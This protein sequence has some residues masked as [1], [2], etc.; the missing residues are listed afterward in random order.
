MYVYYLFAVQ[1]DFSV[2]M[3]P[4]LWITVD[5]GHA[6]GQ[7]WIFSYLTLVFFWCL[8]WPNG[9]NFNN[10][11]CIFIFYFCIMEPLEFLTESYTWQKDLQTQTHLSVT[12]NLQNLA[13]VVSVWMS[14]FI[15]HGKCTGNRKILTV[16]SIYSLPIF[17]C[18][19]VMSGKSVSSIS[20]VFNL[21][22]VPRPWLT[23]V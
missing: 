9:L 15:F 13:N 18:L 14:E 1:W 21:R 3:C 12:G 4:Q 20:A 23:P 7:N 8:Y 16:A 10:S 22:Q 6:C 17:F 19:K 11:S 5:F 2:K